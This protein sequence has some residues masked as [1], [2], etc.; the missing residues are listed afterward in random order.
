MSSDH[1]RSTN[2][3]P[4]FG[5]QFACI[6][7]ANL[8]LHLCPSLSLSLVVLLSRL[9]WNLLMTIVLNLLFLFIPFAY[10]FYQDLERKENALKTTIWSSTAGYILNS[11]CYLDILLNCFTG[12][13]LK[14]GN[15]IVL[16]QSLIIR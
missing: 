16:N 5:T 10:A 7:F 14:N 8:Q 1:F 15:Y 12:Y 6:S 13:Q 11:L 3:K 2:L 9:W 4:D